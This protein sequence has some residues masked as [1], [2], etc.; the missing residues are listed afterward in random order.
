MVKARIVEHTG[1][2]GRVEFVIQQ[3]HSLFRWQ[4]VDAWVNS[5]AGA[6]C[7]DSFSTL[8]EA[9]QNMCWFDGTPWRERIITKEPNGNI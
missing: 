6:S 2:D 9:Q 4:W 5:W 1:P 8:K 3:K 7:R